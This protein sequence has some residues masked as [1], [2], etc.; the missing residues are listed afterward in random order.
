MIR[1]SSEETP[2]RTQFSNGKHA[3]IS[4]SAPDK[5]GSG[6]GFRPHE[7][8]E[9]ALATCMN[10]AIR[11]CAREHGIALTSVSTTVTLDRGKIDEACFRCV[12][13]L[14]E[15]LPPADRRRLIEAAR[16]CSV[17]RTLSRKFTFQGP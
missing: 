12:I 17:H 8:L 6:D 11:M 7:L 15:D 2:Y 14:P 9:A 16:L 13:D 5:G 4:D 10:M 1:T 3:S